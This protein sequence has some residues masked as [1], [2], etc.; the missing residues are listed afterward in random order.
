MKGYTGVDVFKVTHTLPV[1]KGT[2][3]G[4]ASGTEF[5]EGGKADADCDET[6]SEYT[7]PAENLPSKSAEQ[8][9]KKS[10]YVVPQHVERGSA[11]PANR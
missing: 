4:Q 7:P 3:T 11:P 10:T 8:W 9:A 5:Q 1:C 2:K 6:E